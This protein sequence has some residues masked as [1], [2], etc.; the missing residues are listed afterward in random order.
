MC[1]ARI[2][3]TWYM[4]LGTSYSV[5]Y[6]YMHVSWYDLVPMASLPKSAFCVHPHTPVWL[7]QCLYL[8]QSLSKSAT[9]CR[10]VSPSFMFCLGHTLLGYRAGVLPSISIQRPESHTPFPFS[11]HFHAVAA[12]P[13]STDIYYTPETSL[14]VRNPS[15]GLW[16]WVVCCPMHLSVLHLR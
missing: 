4:E 13:G 8:G 16:W 11:I 6:R 9:G 10:R 2:C 14:Q 1:F 5:S 12:R 3:K 7:Y 15:S